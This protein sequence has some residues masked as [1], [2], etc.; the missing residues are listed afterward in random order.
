MNPTTAILIPCPLGYCL[1]VQWP[2]QRLR[3]STTIID[4]ADLRDVVRSLGDPVTVVL[5]GRKRAESVADAVLDVADLVIVPESWTRRVPRS[6][7]TARAELAARVAAA[8]RV[9]TVEHRRRRERQLARP[10]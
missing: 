6:A 8:H 9:A 7:L 2:H 1:W 5:L 4:P 3:A 10:F